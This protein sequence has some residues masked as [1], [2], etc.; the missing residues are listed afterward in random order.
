[1]IFKMEEKYFLRFKKNKIL[2]S[3]LFALVLAIC[4]YYPA[5]AHGNLRSLVDRCVWA[6]TAS[7]EQK[8]A[9][10]IQE[11][12]DLMARAPFPKQP[13]IMISTYDVD[14]ISGVIFKPK[15]HYFPVP[16]NHSGFGTPGP[17]TDQKGKLIGEHIRLFYHRT[18]EAWTAEDTRNY[19]TKNRPWDLIMHFSGEVESHYAGELTLLILHKFY[20][21]MDGLS[22]IMGRGMA[23]A[24]TYRHERSLLG[25]K[26]GEFVKSLSGK[27][28]EKWTAG[29]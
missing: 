18:V 14:S 28:W 1:M 25:E 24:G 2:S 6:L 3:V 20:K 8:L 13:G 16:D 11:R 23:S 15:D 19:Y 10:E 29:V 22:Q 21:E 12:R 9:K 7:R 27:T 17:A 26:I 4:S 5:Q